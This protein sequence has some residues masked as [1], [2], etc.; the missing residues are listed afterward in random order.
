[1]RRPALAAWL[2][3]AGPMLTACASQTP[4]AAQRTPSTLQSMGDVVGDLDTDLDPSIP[5]AYRR[6]VE[7]AQIE[8]NALYREDRAAWLAT[9]ALKA[10]G[11]TMLDSRMAATGWLALQR[12]VEGHTWSVIFTAQSAGATVAY[13]EVLVDFT[14]EP[15]NVAIQPLAEPRPLSDLEQ[16]LHAARSAVLAKD[17]LRCAPSYNT[18]TQFFIDEGRDFIVVRLMPGWTDPARVPMGGFHR[19]RVPLAAG[20]TLEHF[21]QTR[22]CIAADYNQLRP[23]D[24]FAMTLVNSSAP[25]EFDVFASLSYRHPHYAMTEA[26][27]WMIDTGHVRYL[28]EAKE[29]RP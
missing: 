9:D 3:I 16:L 5:A 19:F 21:A 14:H 11:A 1:M 27:A 20:G 4:V 15:P 24:T 8:G 6:A 28:G 12:D 17:W 10:H 13:A 29:P 2:L 18:S 25:T 22:A 23:G 7:A 26:G